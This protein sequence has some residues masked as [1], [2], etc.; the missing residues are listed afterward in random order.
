[1][2]HTYWDTT[3]YV[4]S[5]NLSL[6]DL[7]YDPFSSRWDRIIMHLNPSRIY[8]IELRSLTRIYFYCI[9][10]IWCLRIKHEYH[11]TM[12]VLQCRIFSYY[13]TGTSMWL[14]AFNM[15][16][17]G[18]EGRKLLYIFCRIFCASCIPHLRTSRSDIGWALGFDLGFTFGIF[19]GAPVGYLL[20]CSMIM[21][22]VFT[23]GNY[24]GTWEG[25]LVGFSLVPL[26]G[27]MIGTG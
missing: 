20:K 11:N 14:F 17:R 25:C 22:L 21:L 27:L 24:F 1:M 26:D 4:L 12:Y 15:K 7:T 23:L 2:G 6:D 8:R 9:F 5:R 18:Y 3:W 10:A 16:T 19:M 13:L